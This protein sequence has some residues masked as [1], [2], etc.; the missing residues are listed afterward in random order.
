MLAVVSTDTVL[1]TLGV[2]TTLGVFTADCGVSAICVVIA[3]G[4]V[5]AVG[6]VM[7]CPV[8]VL[9][10]GV[11]WCVVICKQLV[12]IAHLGALGEGSNVERLASTLILDL[13]PPALCDPKAFLS[14]FL[15][16]LFN[17]TKIKN[18]I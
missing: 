13:K 1:A 14:N 3:A 2:V 18:G 12:L 16:N 6:V 7:D 9:D 11:V 10:V 8:E 5:A 4:V 17:S 15:I